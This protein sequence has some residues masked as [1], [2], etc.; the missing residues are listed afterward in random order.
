[1]EINVVGILMGF[2]GGLG[3]LL[4]GLSYMSS[5]LQEVAGDKLRS[6]LEA[7]TKNPIRGVLTGLLVTA[8]VQSSS[9]TTVLTIGLVNSGL[10]SLRRSIGIIMGANIGTTVTAFLIGFNLQNYTMPLLAVSS[11]TILFAKKENIKNIAKSL[12]GFSALFLGLNLMGA[13]MEP[14]KDFPSF[15]STIANIGDNSVLGVLVGTGFTM[16]VQSSSATIGVMQELANQGLIAY[17]QCVPVLFGDNIGTTITALLASIGASVAAKR[18]ALTHF[19]FNFIGTIIFLPL[20]QLGIFTL[21]VSFA[22]DH[23]LLVL[24]G[25]EQ[26]FASMN[27]KMQIAQTHA[28]FNITNTIIQFP[29]IGGL[30]LLVTKLIPDSKE[31][32]EILALKPQYLDKRFLNNPAVALRQAAREAVRMGKLNIKAFAYA[33]EYWNTHDKLVLEQALANEKVI[34]N[35]EKEI[36]DY[37]A[38]ASKKGFNEKDSTDAYTLMRSLHDMERIGDLCENIIYEADYARDNG[39]AFSGEAKKEVESML[40]LTRETINI[41]VTA[42]EN[43]DASLCEQI[44]KNEVT[45]DKM[46]REFRK[47]HINRLNQGICNGNN[48]AVFLELLGNLERMGDHCQNISRYILGED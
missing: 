1:M 32:P 14:L 21:M 24:P 28:V 42:L 19:F 45:L 44:S 40:S 16:M 46:E 18:S 43:K 33:T 23:I 15:V 36:A 26:N 34:D 8:L 30:A 10:L 4:F 5:S 7:G 47:A 38:L 9:A 13:A 35:L 37:I 17:Q 22:T 41:M 31:L 39:V 48:G 20:F 27:I 2:L 12:F 29:F 25:I 3:I 6:I 11:F